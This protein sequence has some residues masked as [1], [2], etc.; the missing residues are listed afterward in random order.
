MSKLKPRTKCGIPI[1]D[2]LNIGIIF[3][4]SDRLTQLPNGCFVAAKNTMLA[5]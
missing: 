3:E 1:N 2:D 4:A 5:G